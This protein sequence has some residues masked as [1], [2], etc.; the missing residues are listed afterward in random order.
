MNDE[1]K[2]ETG[3]E[4]A[5]DEPTEGKAKMT[6][7]VRARI[8]ETKDKIGERGA[9]IREGIQTRK[10]ELVDG[11]NT[12]KDEIVG[13]GKRI[14][15]D[16]E[17]KKDLTVGKLKDG[18]LERLYGVSE[19]A[20]RKVA[21]VV[22]TASRLSRVDALGKPAQK[23]KAR[24]EEL[25]GARTSLARPAIAEYDTLNVKQVNAGLAELNAWELEKV[26]AY[27]AA[28]KGRKTVLREIDR[29]LEQG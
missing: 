25:E 3:T 29:L 23:L 14:K 22:E 2:P 18:G 15:G 9:R 24:A 11:I 28:N 7:T 26:R 13:K 1:N 19:Q 10:D 4:H 5:G 16:L 20:L 21:G 17:R 8:T 6:Q 27:E 12:R